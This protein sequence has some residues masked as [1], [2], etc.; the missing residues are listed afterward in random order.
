MTMQNSIIVTKNL[1]FEYIRNREVLK[2]ISFKIKKGEIFVIMGPSGVGKSTLLR[3]FELLQLPT[4]GELFINDILIKDLSEKKLLPIRRRIG[5]V[6]Q[7]VTLFDG[8]VAQNIGYGLK[9]RKVP[10][11]QRQMLIRNVLSEVGLEGFEKRNIHSLSGG[12]AQRVAIARI[13]VWEPEIILMDEPTANLDPSNTGKI[14]QLIQHINE[15]HN[16]TIVI[17]THNLFQAKRIAHRVGLLLN[18]NFV[19]IDVSNDFF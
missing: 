14:E 5:M 12:E 19:E 18:G 13:L 9:L 8:S 11:Y 3:L 10:R 17:A 16:T 1:N 2:N 7:N 15:I 4:S 6:Y